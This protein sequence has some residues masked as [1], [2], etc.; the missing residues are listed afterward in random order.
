MSPGWQPKVRQMASRVVKR[1]ALALPVLRIERLANVKPTRSASSL[2]DILRLA[3]STS[4][5]TM[6]FPIDT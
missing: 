6:I 5:F 2:S 1:I 4:R 3:I